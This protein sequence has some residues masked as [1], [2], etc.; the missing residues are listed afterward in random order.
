VSIIKSLCH[1]KF[2]ISLE[3]PRRIS[4][5]KNPAIEEQGIASAFNS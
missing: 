5:K 4:K 2:E 3:K 1:L